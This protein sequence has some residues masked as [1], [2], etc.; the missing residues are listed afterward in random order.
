M[1]V[2]GRV[3]EEH[4]SFFI[5]DTD[6]GNVRSTIR[7]TFK[8]D[9]FRVCTGD[10]VDLELTNNEPLEG[11]ITN[12]QTRISFLNRPAVANI[13]QVFLITTIKS[14]S[15]DLEALDR[16]LFSTQVLNLKSIIIIN[17]IDL[18]DNELKKQMND[19]KSIYTSIGYHFIEASA[20]TGLGIDTILDCCT[21]KISAFAG[22]SGVGKSSILSKIFPEKVFRIGNNSGTNER[23]THTTTSVTLLPLKQGGYIADTPGLSFVDIPTVPEEEVINYFPELANRLGL[24]RFNNCIHDGEPGCN[25]QELIQKNEIAVTRHQHYLKFYRQM[26]EIRKKYRKPNLQ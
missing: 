10:L 26:K 9:K 17:K 13:S 7:G 1:P 18:L 14:P 15:I 20:H 8:K 11:V 23:G 16:F 4:K 3:I 19:L 2:S 21:N 24:C 22:L 12:I 25:I 6:Q 5:V